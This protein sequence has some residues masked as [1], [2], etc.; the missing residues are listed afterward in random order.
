[1]AQEIQG[2]GHVLDHLEQT[3]RLKHVPMIRSKIL[4]GGGFY[5][6]LPLSCEGCG[7]GVK[8]DSLDLLAPVASRLSRKYPAPLPTSKMLLYSFKSLRAWRCSQVSRVVTAEAGAGQFLVK[9]VG[10]HNGRHK[11]TEAAVAA[12]EKGSLVKVP[13]LVQG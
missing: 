13:V 1:M 5:R 7:R 10:T 2:R 9:F 11:D 6:D 8:F 12:A 4:D 3:H